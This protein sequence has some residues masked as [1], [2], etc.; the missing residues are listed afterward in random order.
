MGSE[1]RKKQYYSNDKTIDT[2]NI[3][4]Q[5]LSTLTSLKDPNNDLLRKE[6]GLVQDFFE[7]MKTLSPERTRFKRKR[8]SAAE[9]KKNVM[10]YLVF[11]GLKHQNLDY[12]ASQMRAD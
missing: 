10:N 5:D 2:L 7:R 4:K 9:H 6:S 1:K 11:K 12:L 3:V 8:E